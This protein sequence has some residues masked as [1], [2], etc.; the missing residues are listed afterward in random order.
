[1]EIEDIRR[2]AL[3]AL[4]HRLL[5]SFEAEVEGAG[6]DT[7]LQEVIASLDMKRWSYKPVLSARSRALL[8][9]YAPSS[10]ALAAVSGERSSR[11][12][13]QGVEFLDFR[14]YQPG[15][16]LRYADWRAYARTGRL[17][18]RLYQAERAVRL[19]LVVDDSASMS[20]GGKRAYAR[21]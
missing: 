13:G 4:R 9:R 12:P 11:D 7:I 3:P 2:A 5:L 10:R 8:D 16:E 20:V 18:T 14:P 19:H 15:D 6:P 17:Y 21:T 1:V